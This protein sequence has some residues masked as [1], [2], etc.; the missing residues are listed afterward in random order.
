MT[1]TVDEI[2]TALDNFEAVACEN[3]KFGAR[4]TEPD[5]V[6]QCLIRRALYGQPFRAQEPEEWE[7]FT[8][9]MDCLEASQALN[10]EA[11]K[12]CALVAGSR[13]DLRVVKFLDGYC[14]RII[15]DMNRIAEGF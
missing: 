8:A 5:A 9:S 6:F 4:D 11:R 2:K 13:H 12:V 3:A 7:L 14:W 10:R 1:A 15:I